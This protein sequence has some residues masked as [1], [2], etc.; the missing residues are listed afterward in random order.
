MLVI[1]GIQEYF[2]DL[3]RHPSLIYGE[4]DH[5]EQINLDFN[6]DLKFIDYENLSLESLIKQIQ[7]LKKCRF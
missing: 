1:E 3:Q 6:V 7:R 4:K 5:L 2:L